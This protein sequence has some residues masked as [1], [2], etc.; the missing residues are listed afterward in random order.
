MIKVG[1]LGSTGRVGSLLIDDL[2]ND[3]EDGF[4][5]FFYKI[6]KEPGEGGWRWHKWG[7]YI[8]KHDVQH[9]YLADEDL[10]DIGQEFVYIFHLY[11]FR[12]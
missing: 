5:V 6:E 12:A 4:A 2:L 8:G 11:Q 9:E 1:I 7:P 10:S 3:S